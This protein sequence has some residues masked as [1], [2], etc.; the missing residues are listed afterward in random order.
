M[1]MKIESLAVNA[2]VRND[3]GKHFFV[4]PSVRGG[5]AA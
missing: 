3:G 1:R 2:S 5:T 4:R